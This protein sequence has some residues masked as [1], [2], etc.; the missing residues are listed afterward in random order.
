M[1]VRLLLT[2]ARRCTADQDRFVWQTLGRICAPWIAAGELVVLV[3][4]ECPHGGVDLAGRR[5]GEATAGVEVE[6]HPANWSL[7]GKA[8]GAIRNGEMVALGARLCVGFP[9]DESRGTWD[10]LRKAAKAGIP[11]RVYPLG[12][13][14]DSAQEVLFEHDSGAAR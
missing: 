12:P 5:W 14:P 1:T 3:E 10:C 4:G 9:G 7:Y 13:P 8:A 2:G 11:G 6:P